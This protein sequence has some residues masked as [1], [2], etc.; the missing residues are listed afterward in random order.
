MSAQVGYLVLLMELYGCL[1][2]LSL[3]ISHTIA[4]TANDQIETQIQVGAKN[5]TKIMANAP[6]KAARSFCDLAYVS[7]PKATA[8]QRTVAVGFK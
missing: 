5:A 7:K 6:M 3:G 4:I 8:S 1:Y 2:V